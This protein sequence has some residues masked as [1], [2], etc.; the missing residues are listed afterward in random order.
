MRI[1]RVDEYDDGIKVAVV[2]DDDG[3]TVGYNVYGPESYPQPVV[4][5]EETLWRRIQ[6]WWR[7]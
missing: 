6:D 4:S 3:N 2:A 5:G 7:S 1:V